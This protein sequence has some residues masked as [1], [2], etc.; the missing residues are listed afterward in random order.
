VAAAAGL[1]IG[2][3]TRSDL[4]SVARTVYQQRYLSLAMAIFRRIGILN[5]IL[6]PHQQKPSP[7]AGPGTAITETLVF[8]SIFSH[9]LILL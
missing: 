7:V 8:T 5:A 4:H 9:R 2:T 3:K 1:Q 6:S